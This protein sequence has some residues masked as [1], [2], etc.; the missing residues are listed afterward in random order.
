M[1][2][3]EDELKKRFADREVTPTSGQEDL[4]DAISAELDTDGGAAGSSSAGSTWWRYAL[5]AGFCVGAVYFLLPQDEVETAEQR[6]EGTVEQHQEVSETKNVS[7]TLD[8]ADEARQADAVDNAISSEEVK[9]REGAE[10]RPS[11]DSEILEAMDGSV[12]PLGTDS[13]EYTERGQFGQVLQAANSGA[14]R[15]SDVGTADVAKGREIAA[16]IVESG[17]SDA[18]DVSSSVTDQ[19]A[20]VTQGMSNSS[21]LAQQVETHVKSDEQTSTEIKLDHSEETE[22]DH[23]DGIAD[24]AARTAAPSLDVRP[25]AL[26]ADETGVAEELSAMMQPMTLRAAQLASTSGDHGLKGTLDELPQTYVPESSWIPREIELAAGSTW[27]QLDGKL[28]KDYHRSAPGLLGAVDLDWGRGDGL[29]YGLGFSYAQQR[30]IFDYQDTRQTEVLEEDRLINYD[31]DPQTGDTLFAIYEDTWMDALETRTVVHNN[32]YSLIRIP[33]HLGYKKQ[34]G[35]LGLGMDVQVAYAFWTQQAGK[36]VNSE[37]AVVAIDKASP[38]LERSSAVQFGG[39][40]EIDYQLS[41]ALILRVSPAYW[42]QPSV[43][44]ALSGEKLGVSATSLR[45]GLVLVLW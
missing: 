30:R 28:Q 42:L 33:L 14:P 9:T 11:S 39:R 41:D 7:E 20:R 10:V 44:S 24:Y 43:D 29:R 35:R 21:S 6:G 37:G 3:L 5:I 27:L 1:G 12:D 22:L 16:P 25:T 32:S 17:R 4:W 26:P 31:L 15:S 2:I 23:S 19:A 45:A 8:L 36:A 40:A 34:L 18:R 13:N 38:M